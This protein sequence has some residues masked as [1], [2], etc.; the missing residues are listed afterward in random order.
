MTV[1][2][3]IGGMLVVLG[4]AI[5]TLTELVSIPVRSDPVASAAVTGV[6]AIITLFIVDRAR[7]PHRDWLASWPVLG[8]VVGRSLAAAV[9]RPERAVTVGPGEE[10]E[11][12]RCPVECPARSTP[13]RR[14]GWP[15][16]S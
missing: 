13:L 5:F 4:T 10:E 7:G 11:Q 14:W 1:S 3:R 2:A 16:C 6:I 9:A 15:R 12:V 8:E